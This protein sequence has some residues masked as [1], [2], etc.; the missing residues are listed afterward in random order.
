MMKIQFICRILCNF[1]A[2]VEV[3]VIGRLDKLK[4]KRLIS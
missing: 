4:E 1:A 3:K 2:K